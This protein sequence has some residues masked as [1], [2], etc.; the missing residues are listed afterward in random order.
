M[1]TELK[2]DVLVLREPAGNEEYWVAQC[3][4]YDLVAQAKTLHELKA[5]FACVLASHIILSLDRKMEPFSNLSPAPQMYWD[6]FE[7]HSDFESNFPVS[8][9]GDRIPQKLRSLIDRIPRGEAF[10]RLAESV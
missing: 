1:K 3:L 10:M 7:R 4:Q 6:Q 5:A 2:L 8:V 9:P